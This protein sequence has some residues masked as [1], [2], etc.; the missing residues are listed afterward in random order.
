MDEKIFSH[1][2][3][4][5]NECIEGLAIKPRGIYLDATTGGG[6]HSGLIAA[7]LKG[8]KLICM[9]RDTDALDAAKKKLDAHDA[10]IIYVHSNFEN[11]ASGEMERYAGKIDG[12]LFDLGVSSFQLD[13]VERGFSYMKDAPLDMR[14]DR[15]QRFSAHEV[16]NSY[17]EDALKRIISL[18]GEERYAGRIASAICR[19]RGAAEIQTTARLTEII[20]SA[21]PAKAKREKQHP[22]KRTFQAI[23]MEVNGELAAI[24][25]GLSD[26]IDMLAPGGR[27]AVI[28]FHSLEDRLVKTV[29]AEKARGCICPKSAPVCICGQTPIVRLVNKKVIIPTD[30]EIET[31]HRAR[32]AKL[33]IAEKI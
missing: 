7:N 6:G 22:A 16:V 26:G 1:I 20:T 17:D 18:Y 8:G 15:Q 14:M 28:S 24:E 29:F 9:D 31:N 23:R 13:T 19:E 10:E 5:P 21:M 4:L 3:V 11:I 12:M 33:R 27:I 2:S 30:A 25:K 32:S